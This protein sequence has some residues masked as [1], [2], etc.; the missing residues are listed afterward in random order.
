MSAIP[1][2]FGTSLD[3]DVACARLFEI[4]T[5][6]GSLSK[7]AH[8]KRLYAL[9]ES[10]DTS[11]QLAIYLLKILLDPNITTGLKKVQMPGLYEK[12]TLLH[13]ERLVAYIET[14]ITSNMNQTLRDILQQL[15]SLC[16]FKT[17][18]V[19]AQV[20][21]KTFK[22]G[23]TIKSVN[24]VIPDFAF[25]MQCM[26]AD[27]PDDKTKMTLPIR[28]DI[29]YDGVRVLAKVEAGIVTLYTRQGKILK[30]PELEKEIIKLSGGQNCVLDGEIESVGGMRTSISGLVT[31]NIASGYHP[32]H[33]MSIMYSVFDMLTVDEFKNKVCTRP[34]RE[35]QIRL[36]NTFVNCKAHL[37]K[38]SE[39]KF[40]ICHTE[41]AVI[42]TTNE[43]IAAGFEGT[44]VKDLSA[45]YCFGRSSAWLKYKA[46]N[47]CTLQCV[48]VTEGTNKRKG[49]VGALVCQSSCGK[50]TVSVGGGM[51]DADIELFTKV[52]P[53]GKFVEVLFNVLIEGDPGQYSL[54][55]PRLSHLKIRIDKTEADSL[56]KILKE[57]IGKPQLKSE[58]K[59][60]AE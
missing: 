38:I 5:L 3:V 55:L 45:T 39:A 1:D 15:L 9:A 47:S 28:V 12:E 36:S 16:E 35:R 53:V 34:L 24:D 25:E 37:Q 20:L 33:D 58:I 14:I 43:L 41:E 52:S 10:G 44:I 13:P 19:L 7:K 21:Q 54:F 56:S 2:K 42:T 27:S 30:L 57:H 22:I 4:Y 11:A 48:G 40:V 23:L 17:A 46:V 29:K 31:S 6:G 50:V 51:D 60:D 8:V 32:S 26:L 59:E 49:K 18:T